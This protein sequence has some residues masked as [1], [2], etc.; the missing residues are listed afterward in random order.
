MPPVQRHRAS[1]LERNHRIRLRSR[2]GPAV[3]HD[4]VGGDVV[5]RTVIA[6]DT[7]AVANGAG[8]DG[9]EDRVGEGEGEKGEEGECGLHDCGPEG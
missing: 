7:H 4:V 8:V 5:D 2:I 1:S 6:G 3:T 9:D